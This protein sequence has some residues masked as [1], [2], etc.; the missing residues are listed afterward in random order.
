MRSLA[1]SLVMRIGAKLALS[2][3]ISAFT[4]RFSALHR[5][6]LSPKKPRPAL[7]VSLVSAASTVPTLTELPPVPM[8]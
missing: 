4:L 7:A 3:T 1:P 6:W 2:A 8:P 5:N